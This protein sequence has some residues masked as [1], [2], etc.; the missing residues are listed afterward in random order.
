MEKELFLFTSMFDGWPCSYWP[1]YL[2]CQSAPF[3]GYNP[4]K[5]PALWLSRVHRKNC[6]LWVE[7]EC[8]SGGTRLSCLSTPQLVHTRMTP[9]F[10]LIVLGFRS[11]V[12]AF[13]CS[14]ILPKQDFV[15]GPRCQ[16]GEG[17]K[18]SCPCIG[19]AQIFLH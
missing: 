14:L 9:R 19:Y 16:T 2:H 8:F 10:N 6:L 15:S 18:R 1:S 17:R 13:L 11:L 4:P 12:L 5:L 7:R 3:D